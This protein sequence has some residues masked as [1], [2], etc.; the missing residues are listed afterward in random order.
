MYLRKVLSVVL[1]VVAIAAVTVALTGCAA[2]TGASAWGDLDTGLIL[3]YRMSSGDA[4]SYSFTSSSIQT[5][6]IQ[7]QPVP[8]ESVE[9]LLFSVEPKGVKD[10]GHALGITIED[11]SVTVSSPRGELE[12]DTENVVGE[13]FDMTLSKLG[14]EGGLP[15]PDVLQ[16]MIGSEGPKSVITGFSVIFPDL[17]EGPI[18]VGDTWPTTVEISEQSDEGDVVITVAAVNTLEGFETIGSFECAKIAAVLTGTI[19][20]SGT[21]QGAE[22]T[23]QSDMDGSGKWYFAYKEGIL[24]SDVTEGT[25]DGNIVV[26]APNGEMTIPVSRDY[27]MVTELVK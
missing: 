24:V 11:L 17:P 19:E 21:Q 16:Y 20:G 23:M 15:D 14:A 8:V 10:G 6:E 25:A 27:S 12:A 2:K 1:C 13:S 26:Q 9:T 7:G 4:M 5:M 22:W 3:E 18:T